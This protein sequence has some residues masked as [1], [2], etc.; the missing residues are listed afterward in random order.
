MLIQAAAHGLLLS[1]ASNVSPSVTSRG[2]AGQVTMN[3]PSSAGSNSRLGRQSTGRCFESYRTQEERSRIITLVVT[4]KVALIVILAWAVGLC[5]QPASPTLYVGSA[6]CQ[7]CHSEIYGRWKKTRMA[8]VVRDPKEYPDAIT[9]DLTKPD[10]VVT[11]TKDDIAFVYGSKW[12]QR[13]FKRIGDDYFP[14]PA[15]WD[16]THQIWRPYNV[17]PGTDWWT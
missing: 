7:Q 8:N 15:Q 6:A 12:K 4:A 10:P 17:K 9:P 13:Y 16:V 14:L 2:R 1:P 5:A 3:P 11:F